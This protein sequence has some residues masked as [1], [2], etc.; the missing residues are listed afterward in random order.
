MPKKSQ[1]WKSRQKAKND[2]SKVISHERKWKE[3]E[4]S[5]KTKKKSL[6]SWLLV[7]IE[8]LAKYLKSKQKPKSKWFTMKQSTQ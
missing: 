1:K 2:M 3:K 5:T 6:T 8:T 7:S 4:K